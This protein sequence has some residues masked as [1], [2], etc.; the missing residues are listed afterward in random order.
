VESPYL[1]VI[2]GMAT[3][4][5]LEKI[6]EENNGVVKNKN[7]E[8]F[9]VE[10]PRRILRIK[11][12]KIEGIMR[13]HMK[14]RILTLVILELRFVQEMHLDDQ[15]LFM[16]T[17][18]VSPHEHVTACR[19]TIEVS[20]SVRAKRTCRINPCFSKKRIEGQED[21]TIFLRKDYG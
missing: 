21:H 18:L 9:Q 4:N 11:E 13:L 3:K 10:V 20:P 1:A 2:K 6:I 19:R 8:S 15:V 14:R 16:N 7:W 17:R 5:S 12:Y